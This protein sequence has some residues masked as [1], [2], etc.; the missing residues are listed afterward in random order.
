M[1][2]CDNSLVNSLLLFKKTFNNSYFP[3]LWKKSNIIPVHKKMANKVLIII[4][5][6]HCFLFSIFRKI[7]EK[8]EFK[9][10]YIFLQNEQLLNQNESGLR[11]SD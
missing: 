10:I 4:A 8:M 6:F 11:S 7:F 2:I 1:K 5:L 3:D 9:K